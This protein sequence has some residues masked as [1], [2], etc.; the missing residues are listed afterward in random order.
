MYFPHNKHPRSL[1][2]VFRPITN[3]A[4]PLRLNPLARPTTQSYHRTRLQNTLSP[5]PTVHHFELCRRAACPGWSPRF[6]ALLSSGHLGFSSA[7][8]R[9]GRQKVAWLMGRSTGDRGLFHFSVF[10][11][12]SF[13]PR[14]RPILLHSTWMWR[15]AEIGAAFLGAADVTY[16]SGRLGGRGA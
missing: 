14:A 3:R 16:F 6:S 1:F 7:S 12:L 15:P 2:V 9:Q 13:L 11:S 4:F 8:G 10:V 5:T